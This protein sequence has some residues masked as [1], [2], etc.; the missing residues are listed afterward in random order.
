MDKN[1]RIGLENFHILV[2][3]L[4]FTRQMTTTKVG[5]TMNWE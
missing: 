3:V 4:H 2:W 1:I 5:L